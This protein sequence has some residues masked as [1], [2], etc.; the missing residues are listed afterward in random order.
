[1]GRRYL[2]SWAIVHMI[3]MTVTLKIRLVESQQEIVLNLLLMID[4][5]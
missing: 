3:S 5:L 4:K 1:M 2:T